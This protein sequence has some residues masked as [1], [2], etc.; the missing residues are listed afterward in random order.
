MFVLP[1]TVSGH[2]TWASTSNHCLKII[3]RAA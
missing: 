3:V 2:G 1:Q